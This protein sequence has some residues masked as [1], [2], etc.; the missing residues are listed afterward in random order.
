MEILINALSAREG[1]GVTYIKHLLPALVREGKSH[2]YHVLLSQRYQRNLIECL[3]LE[4]HPLILDLRA[5]P[6]LYRWWY[7]QRNLPKLLR[8]R[9]FGLLLTVNEIGTLWSP[10]PH[11]V[12]VRNLNIYAPLVALS[13]WRDRMRLLIYRIAREPL[14][15]LTL[16][17]ADRIVFVSRSFCRQVTEQLHL[18]PSKARVVYHGVNPIFSTVGNRVKGDGHSISP[19]QGPYLLAVSTIV[20]HKNYKT[21]LAAFAMVRHPEGDREVNLAIAGGIGDVALYRSLKQQV[22]AL[23]ISD[24]VHFLGRVEYESL[25]TLYR[26]AIALIFPSRLE[27]FGHPLVEAMASGT[28]VVASDLPVCH[29]ICQDAALYFQPDDVTGLANHITALL[30][31]PGLRQSLREKGLQRAT[32]FSWEH[33]AA[34]MV[35]IFE[36]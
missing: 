29:E 13:N 23:A 25:P 14:A 17:R 24:R 19:E 7:I 30:K 21:L 34:Q 3:P 15:Y 10:C 1:G 33:T 28:P 20:P 35:R 31:G 5:T 18:E 9:R 6:L 32:Q 2:E 16:R 12:L 26:N 4:V 8:Q 11:V 27:T 36:E 22:Q